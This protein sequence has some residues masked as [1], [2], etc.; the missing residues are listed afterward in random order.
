MDLLNELPRGN[1]A[2]P[3]GKIPREF[4]ERPEDVAGAL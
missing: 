1:P 2:K 3:K 4:F